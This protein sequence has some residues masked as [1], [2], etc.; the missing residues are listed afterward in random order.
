VSQIEDHLR[1]FTTR[2]T[3]ERVQCSSWTGFLPEF[4]TLENFMGLWTA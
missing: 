2:V 4:T 3:R 1:N